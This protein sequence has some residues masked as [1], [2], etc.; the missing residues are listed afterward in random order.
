MSDDVEIKNIEEAFKIL[1]K[2]FGKPRG[3]WES[4]RK[5]FQNEC[6]NPKGWPAKGS[7]ERHQL[8]FKMF[9]LLKRALQ[10]SIEYEDLSNEILSRK[11]IHAV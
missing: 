8:T 7:F 1:I 2:A 5:E 6:S 10:Y 9:E 3:V 4:I 11:T